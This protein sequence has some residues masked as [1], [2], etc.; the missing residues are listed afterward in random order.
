MN[1][2]RTRNVDLI[3]WTITIL[4]SAAP[5]AIKPFYLQPVVDS[6]KIPKFLDSIATSSQGTNGNSIHLLGILGAAAIL[7]LED[8][9]NLS[10]KPL[11]FPRL[12]IQALVATVPKCA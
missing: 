10:L 11:R 4:M 5:P 9:I 1:V 3:R 2:P 8:I 6:L 7:A 12:W